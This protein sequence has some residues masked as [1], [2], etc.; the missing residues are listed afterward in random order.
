MGEVFVPHTSNVRW[1]VSAATGRA[2]W[3]WPKTS[4]VGMR[5]PLRCDEGQVFVGRFLMARGKTEN[6]RFDVSVFAGLCSRS[7]R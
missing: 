4:S 5:R 7:E 3:S 1:L 2:A 6:A